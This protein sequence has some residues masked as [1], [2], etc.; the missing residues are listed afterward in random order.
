MEPHLFRVQIRKYPRAG[1][2]TLRWWVFDKKG[3]THLDTGVIVGGNR[4]LAERAAK[5]AIERL[6]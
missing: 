2:M 1:G 5:D 3:G 4:D 6:K